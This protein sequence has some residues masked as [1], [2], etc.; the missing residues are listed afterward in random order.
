MNSQQQPEIARRNI[1][2]VF[3]LL[4]G[5]AIGLFVRRVKIGL[6]IGIVLG[7]IAISLFRR[8]RR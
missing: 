4:L 8:P 6:I 2:A 5:L 7:F 1:A 3:A